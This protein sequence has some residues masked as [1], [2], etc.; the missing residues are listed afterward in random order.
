[1]VSLL[2]FLYITHL[3]EIYRNEFEGEFQSNSDPDV[4]ILEDSPQRISTSPNSASGPSQSATSMVPS[5]STSIPSSLPTSLVLDH[6]TSTLSHSIPRLA[7]PSQNPS[8]EQD[9]DKLLDAYLSAGITC[10][11]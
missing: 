4:M 6:P 5:Q 2:Q 11:K 7:T 3:L 10:G 1:M 9:M 8:P